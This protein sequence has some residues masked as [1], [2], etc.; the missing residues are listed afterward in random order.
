[1]AAIG[2]VFMLLALFIILINLTCQS[3]TISKRSIFVGNLRSNFRKTASSGR[4]WFRKCVSKRGRRL[5]MLYQ[6]NGCFPGFS[7]SLTFLLLL[8]GD[9]EVNPG[10]TPSN[11]DKI[12]LEIETED[13][14]IFLEASGTISENVKEKPNMDSDIMAFLR[15]LK[16][17]QS[18]IKDNLA[19]IMSRINSL[20]AEFSNVKKD[21]VDLTIRQDTMEMNH[22]G[23]KEDVANN[24]YR[25]QDVAFALDKQ[26]QYSRKSSVRILNIPEEEKENIQDVVIKTLKDNIAVT[27]DPDEI[28]IVHR[29][30]RFQNRDQGKHRAVLIKFISHKSKMRIMKEKKKAT[31]IKIFED[32]APGVKRML[33]SLNVNRIP[34]N[35]ESVWTIDG[36]IKFKHFN[37]NRI[38][39]IRT[40]GDYNS[41]LHN[42]NLA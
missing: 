4:K 19:S 39:E 9:V 2:R 21:M 20:E 11:F 41:L 18:E 3:R 23:I 8:C 7:L 34:L 17:G 35:L 1:M 5:N 37:N 32:L 40:F 22:E 14:D 42:F 13:Q 16:V 33:D 31:G 12:E 30:G 10:P 25:L 29:V 27:I 6:S 24:N 15:D 38:S 26:E 28:D 36:R